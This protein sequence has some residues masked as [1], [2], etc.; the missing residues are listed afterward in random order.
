MQTAPKRGCVKERESFSLLSFFPCFHART[1]TAKRVDSELC[2]VTVTTS[3]TTR[4]HKPWIST[5]DTQGKR[6]RQIF[7]SRTVFFK[8]R[9]SRVLPTTLF[10]IFLFSPTVLLAVW[11]STFPLSPALE[12]EGDSGAVTVMAAFTHPG[13]LIMR[14]ERGGKRAPG[15]PALNYV[16]HCVA[17]YSQPWMLTLKLYHSL[18][19]LSHPTLI[20][21]MVEPTCVYA[22]VCVC[23]YVCE[24]IPAQFRSMATETRW[25]D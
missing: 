17:G 6:E 19:P 22:R 18:S 24:C 23:V 15:T 13:N 14:R 1:S 12:V 7:H 11:V 4:T 21:L 2:V 16:L 3:R 10:Y 8:R 5:L 20:L 9:A 25:T